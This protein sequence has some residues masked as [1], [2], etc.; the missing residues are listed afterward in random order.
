MADTTSNETSAASKLLQQHIAAHPV[1][2]EEVPD[3]EIGKPVTSSAEASN[4]ESKPTWAEP[5]SAKAAGK[6]KAQEAK[7]IDTSSHDL[8]PELGGPRSTSATGT[9]PIWNAKSSANG[10]ADGASPTNGTPQASAPPSGVTTP[11]SRAPTVLIPGRNTETFYAEP[12]HLLPRTQLKRPV[13]DVLKD[14]NRKSRA[15]VTM[16]NAANGKLKFEATGPEGV[17]QQ[18]IRELMNHIGS[19]VGP[20]SDL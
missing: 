12:H 2:I 7:G 16:S 1:T 9:V 15:K 20:P 10:K 3:E 6:Q 17:A 14:L 8:F 5:M 18:A 19:K 4:T 11:T 13:V